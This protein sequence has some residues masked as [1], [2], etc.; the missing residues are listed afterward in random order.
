MFY[1]WPTFRHRCVPRL[2][3]L[4]TAPA[5]AAPIGYAFSGTLSQPYNGSTQFS[6]TFYYDTNLL[7]FEMENSAADS[8]VRSQS[9]SVPRLETASRA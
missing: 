2:L 5:N 4:A 6:G 7:P 9:M 8:G 1:H 3:R